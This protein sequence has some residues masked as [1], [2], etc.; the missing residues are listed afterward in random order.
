[1]T[2]P[3][4]E[5]LNERF[6]ELAHTDIENERVWFWRGIAVYTKLLSELGQKEYEQLKQECGL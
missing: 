6:D 1:M 4:T 5:E 2:L 3:T